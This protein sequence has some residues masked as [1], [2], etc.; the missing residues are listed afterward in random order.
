MTIS[1][2]KDTHARSIPLTS[3][4]EYAAIRPYGR[5]AN[6]L[7]CYDR[8]HAGLQSEQFDSERVS[9]AIKKGQSI[10]NTNN[11]VTHLDVLH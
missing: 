10:G 3:S 5:S 11:K 9:L 1:S 8:Q 2:S 7:F 6:T 4:S